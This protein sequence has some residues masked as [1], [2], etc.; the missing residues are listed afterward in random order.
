MNNLENDTENASDLVYP[1]DELFD[2]LGFL[3]IDIY[4]Y[5]IIIPIIGFIAILLSLISAWIFFKKKFKIAA[6]DY[7]R[8]ITIS[9][10]IQL[11]FAIP[12][13]TCFTP[14]YF[15][16]MDSYACAIVQSVY[17]PYSLFVAHYIAILEIGVLFETIK[18]MNP[19]VKKHFTIKPKKMIVITIVLCLFFNSVSALVY[20]PFYGGDFF[21]YNKS[22]SLRTNSFWYV[23]VSSLASSFIGEIVLVVFYFVRDILTSITTIILNIVAMS[24]M[25]EY[26]K[27]R[28]VKFGLASNIQSVTIQ[29][30]NNT[31]LNVVSQ[32][33]K[34]KKSEKNYIKLGVTMCLIS[35]IMRSA[36]IACDVY[37]LFSTDYIAT[38]LGAILDLVL[39]LGPAVSFF[40]FYH[41][42]REFHKC[43]LKIVSDLKRKFSDIYKC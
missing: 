34:Q 16:S 1:L 9:H 11:M 2:S 27:V 12:Y 40:V 42:N 43:F 38:L 3:P 32:S 20:V 35:T 36:L 25:R 39:V 24:E 23:S 37:Y 15:P 6:Y 5:Q 33:R 4:I 31:S 21:Y 7:L 14:Y 18:I 13:G 22:G 17:I 41:F 26:F 8:V 19:F 10:I 29:T 28:S 30:V